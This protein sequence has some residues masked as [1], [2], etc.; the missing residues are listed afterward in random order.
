VSTSRSAVGTEQLASI[1][2]GGDGTLALSVL[3]EIEEQP[4][5]KFILQKLQ[6]LVPK[7]SHPIISFQAK[8]TLKI[9]L[10]KATGDV[11]KASLGDL[12]LLL[13]DPTKIEE[14][15][16]TL[17]H[18]SA[19]DSFLATDMLR[20]ANWKDF[21]DP[22]LP[23]FC[24]YFKKFGNVVDS[25]SLI[26]LSRH[27]DP[28]VM[29]SALEALEIVDPANLQ[30]I[31]MPLLSST[32]PGIRAKAIQILYRWDKAS[33]LHYFVSML[34]SKD[35]T[36]QTLALH[37]AVS[38]PYREIE[39]H[40]LRFLAETSDPKLLMKVSQVFKMHAYSDLPFKLYWVFKNL[41]GN[42][43][44]LVKGI[45]I[46]LIRTLAEKKI[47][48][49][50][51]EEFLRELKER[52]QKE[53]ENRLRASMML[54]SEEKEPEP[55]HE[56]SKSETMSSAPLPAST[57]PVAFHSIEEYDKLDVTVR[58]QLLSKMNAEEYDS[59]KSRIPT[60][61]KTTEGKELAALIRVVGR[62]G[63]RS[64]AEGFKTFLNSDDPDIVCAGIDAL[65][66][67]DAEYLSIFLPQLM[68]NKNGKIRMKATRAFV[69]IDREQIKSLIAGMLAANPRQRLMAVPISTL[70]DFGIVREPLL[71]ALEKETVGEI[72]EKIGMV[73]CANPD[74]ELFREIYRIMKKAPSD[75]KKEF[76]NL[77]TQFASKLSI[78]LGKI[79]SPEELIK[80]EETNYHNEKIAAEQSKVVQPPKKGVAE[81]LYDDKKPLQS[82]QVTVKEI[83]TSNEKS[84]KEKR[85]SLTIFILVL[86]G[87]GWIAMIAYFLLNR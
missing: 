20:A 80:I 73:L 67:L 37:H 44:D 61:L 38:F 18:L 49:V 62:F 77:V 50:S 25:D 70:V 23:T 83:F 47:I 11:P 68:Q 1:L 27:A 9:S 65:S 53:E 58:V 36:E 64:E 51:P 45:I 43:K 57:T 14:I 59:F 82:D 35:T 15:A 40:L 52:I 39:P 86:A 56:I 69:G 63:I 76:D 33:A 29:T 75:L 84:V 12:Q 31:V 72:V 22:I 48:S 32:I 19:T 26:E 30:S 55:A 16:V 81:K 6:E 79:S 13:S 8:K 21:P 28:I 54:V 42:H 7:I 24:R 87:I 41:S 74:R 2:T 3:F 5:S 4:P 60:L 17:A 10:Q 66:T 34:F 46:G 85:A 71:K 78:A